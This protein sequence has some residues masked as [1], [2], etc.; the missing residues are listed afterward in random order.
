MSMLQDLSYY[1]ITLVVLSKSMYPLSSIEH[2]CTWFNEKEFFLLLLHWELGRYYKLT[3]DTSK[4]CNKIKVYGCEFMRN[5]SF[6]VVEAS[7]L[8]DT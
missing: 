5:F 6:V 3:Y 4:K 8:H 1:A 7:I 2:L